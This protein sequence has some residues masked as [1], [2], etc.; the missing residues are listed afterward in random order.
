MGGA[1]VE[2]AA[3]QQLGIDYHQTSDDGRIRL[4]AV[5]CLGNCACSPAIMVDEKLYS[6]V[7][8]ESLTDILTEMVNSLPGQES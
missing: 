8:P 2:A 6:R 3:R 4:Q 1:A 7:T 5:Y